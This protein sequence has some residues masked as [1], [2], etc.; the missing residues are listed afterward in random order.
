[1]SINEIRIGQYRFSNNLGIGTFGK[2]K[3]KSTHT[4]LFT[5]GRPAVEGLGSSQWW[6]EW[7]RLL[8]KRKVG[9]DRSFCTS[10]SPYCWLDK[11]IGV[12]TLASPTSSAPLNPCISSPLKPVPF[13]L[14]IPPNNNPEGLWKASNYLELQL[15]SNVQ[16]SW[17]TLYPSYFKLTLKANRFTTNNTHYI[18]IS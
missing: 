2:V 18:L 8:Q 15:G 6:Q 17:P 3:S 13:K 1:M 11:P 5:E 12:P 10:P 4:L 9:S 7:R 16:P 14:F